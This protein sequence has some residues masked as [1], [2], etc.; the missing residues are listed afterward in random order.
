[1][2]FTSIVILLFAFTCASK[3]DESLD[4]KSYQI[5]TWDVNHID[6]Q[7]P[8]VLVFKNGMMDSEA[9]H[10]YGFKAAAYTSTIKNGETSFSGT[11]SSE[12]EGTIKIDGKVIEKQIQGTMLWKKHGQADIKYGYKGKLK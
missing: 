7:D 3:T 8:D 12:T 6:K 9:C 2:N 11:I 10:Q 4:G 5:L 1:M